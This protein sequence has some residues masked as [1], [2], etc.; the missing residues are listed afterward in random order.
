MKTQ[1]KPQLFFALAS[2]ALNFCFAPATTAA[3]T[4][5]DYYRLGEDDPGA[6]DNAP[7]DSTTDSVGKKN[8][9]VVGGPFWSTDV[10][11]SASGHTASVFSFQ[12]FQGGPY[13][14]TSVLTNVTDNFGIEAWVKPATSSGSH[15]I[16]YNGNT[17]ANGWGLYQV[18]NT[19]RGRFAGVTIGSGSVTLNGWTHIALVRTNGTARL[20]INGAAAG[21]SSTSTP[22]APSGSFAIAAPPQTHTNEFFSGRIDEVRVFTFGSGQFSPSDLLVNAGFPPPT[23]VAQFPTAVSGTNATLNATVNPRGDTTTVYL[24]YGTT[25]SYGSFTPTNLIAGSVAVGVSKVV[26]VVPNTVYHFRTVAWNSSGQTVGPDV[27]FTNPVARPQVT[28]LAASN[29]TGTN[30]SLNASINPGGGATSFYFQYG[31]TTNYGSWSSTNS[32]AAG[33]NAVFTNRTVTGLLPATPYHFRVVASNSSGLSLGSNLSFAS[34]ALSNLTVTTTNNSGAGSLRQAILGATNTATINFAVT[35]VINLSSPLPIIT[36]GIAFN[37]PGAAGLTISAN[38][39]NRIFFVDAP[40]NTV[41]FSNI[42]L[43]NGIAKGGDGGLGDSGGGGGLGAGGALFVNAGNVVI[44]GVAFSNS[45]AVGGR[46]GDKIVAT[47]SGGGGGLGGSG[48]KAGGGGGG[49]GG[50]TGRGGDSFSSAGLPGSGGGGGGLFG[51]GG[52]SGQQTGGGGGAVGDGQTPLPLSLIGGAGG[53]GG[54]GKG[55]DSASA[56]GDPLGQAGTVNGGG[57]GGGYSNAGA[58]GGSGGRFGGGGGANGAGIGGPGGEFGGGGGNGDPRPGFAHSGGPGGFGAGGGGAAGSVSGNGGFGGGSGGAYVIS[59]TPGA[60]GG[61]GGR[62]AYSAGAGGGGGAALGGAIFVRASNGATLTLIDSVPDA[63]ALTAGA[64]GLGAFCNPGDPNCSDAGAGTAAGSS[65]FLLGGTNTLTFNT[66]VSVLAGTIGGWDGAPGVLIKNGDGTLALAGTNSYPGR[67]LVNAGALRVDGSIVSSSNVTVN[68]GATLAGSGSVSSLTLNAG[69]TISPGSS[70]GVLSSGSAVWSGAGNYNWQVYNA[71]GAAGTGYDLLTVNGSLNVSGASG[72]KIN[73]WTLS[74]PSPETSGNAIN[75][76]NTLS[77]SWTLVQTTGGIIGF[78]PT[79]FIINADPANGTDG[80]ANGLAGGRF[81]LSVVGN[82]LVLNFLLPPVATVQAANPV[83]STNA[84][85]NGTVSPGGL[86]TTWYF[87]YGT[88]VGDG[89]FTSSFTSTNTLS[90]S[91]NALSVVSPISGLTPGT[92]YYFKLMAG[93]S[94]GTNSSSDGTFVTPPLAPVVSTQPASGV[95]ANSATL[96]GLVY[97]GNGGSTTWYFQYGLTTNYGSVTPFNFVTGLDP[98]AVSNSIS[99]L[100]PGA[101]YHARLMAANISGSAS[102]ADVTFTTPSAPPIAITQGASGITSSN[103]VMYALIYPGGAATS[104]YFQYGLTTNYGNFTGTNSLSADLSSVGVANPL[105]GL[106]PGTLYHFR[107]VA[108]NSAGTSFGTNAEFATLIAPPGAVTLAASNLSAT[109]A[110]LNATINPGG[111]PTSYYFQFGATTN[112]GSFTA[113]NSLVAA[114]SALHFNGTNQSVNTTLSL[115]LSNVSF[116]V[117]FWA[118]RDGL[119][120]WDL[121]LAQ[122]T[123]G[124]NSHTLHIGWRPSN[125]FTFGFWGDDLNTPISYTN[126]DWHHWACTYDASSKSRIIYCDGVVV[127]SGTAAANYLGKGP[128]SIAVAAPLGA[129]F[130]GSLDDLRIWSGVRSAAQIAASLNSQLTGVEPGLLASWEFDEGSGSATA[131]DSTGNS[132][133]GV[134]VNSPAWLPRGA[135]LNVSN[136]I[137]G[138]SPGTLYHVRA[139]SANIRGSATAGDS[140]F[141]TPPL[142]PTVQ[143]VAATGI[144]SSNAILN[145][146]INPGAGATSYYFEYGLNT[147]YGSFTVTNSLVP[148]TNSVSA[149]ATIASLSQGSRYHFRAV[150]ANAAGRINGI[151][152]TFT[153]A[154]LAN[155]PTLEQAVILANGAF[156]FGFTNHPGVT[157]TVIGATDL[158]L[159]LSNWT[160]LGPAQEVSPG[161][162]QFSDSQSTN[163]P[164]RF[165][166]VKSP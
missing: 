48:G 166:R 117:E 148:G 155:P 115:N 142:A 153:T 78:N 145:A 163:H 54:G 8:L 4:V 130:G 104:Y 19:Y 28:T 39:S 35:G 2:V 9:A 154:A 47:G 21:T 133:T 61:T 53:S 12:F 120:R 77:R 1:H 71:S 103:A 110:T 6:R 116:S 165:Y 59:G 135:S 23:I 159:E 41:I 93:N 72:F 114:G 87:Q 76:T 129:W 32:L 127:A 69:A 75:F 149:N 83:T 156:Q 113:T 68:S 100:L 52:V 40:G 136:A 143:T 146:I 161:Q 82:N 94:L 73:L 84:T 134:L 107:P 86:T 89:S 63:G 97:P 38:N 27:T 79:N 20:Y 81:T 105:N 30:A 3:V 67:T 37:G 7:M 99:E 125:V 91:N 147:N 108:L 122:G 51:N 124:V 50:F 11:S 109:G 164:Q 66:G 151:G 29:L 57:G 139:V 18:G 126:S 74:S 160:V 96:N 95:T 58:N 123:A 13:G 49:G 62:S 88:A 131:A 112:Y 22:V 85:L 31:T 121:P 137:S 106:Q 25:A 17:A 118:K 111:A 132:N 14:I 46:G 44:S 162:F 80:F 42:T 70:P 119:N 92:W 141:T 60:F 98:V 144:T 36:N 138:L 152:L 64:G 16:A 26:S 150:A 55:G 5:L 65:I 90:S 34:P 33:T 56:G 43:A 128:V 45:A 24:Q 101:L 157:F 15:C 140:T 10:S 102:G 158:S